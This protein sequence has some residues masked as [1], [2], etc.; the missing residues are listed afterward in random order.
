MDPLL[1]ST[2]ALILGASILTLV[3]LGPAPWIW[4][5]DRMFGHRMGSLGRRR[6]PDRLSPEST[7]VD[8]GSNSGRRASQILSRLIDI[9]DKEGVEAVKRALAEHMRRKGPK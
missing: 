9:H 8:T 3:A 4:S 5:W 2:V 7:D 1:L 6:D